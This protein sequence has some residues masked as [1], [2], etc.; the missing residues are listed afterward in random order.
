MEP[1]NALAPT[2]AM[3]AVFALAIGGVMLLR[4]GRDRKRAW[5]ML[6]LSLVLLANVAIGT[7]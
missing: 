4:Q 1:L 2:I 6:V 7:L 3:L 5:L